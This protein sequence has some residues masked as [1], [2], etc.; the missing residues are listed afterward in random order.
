MRRL[1]ITALST[2]ILLCAP[3]SNP[4]GC[5]PHSIAWSSLMTN[6]L[7]VVAP[8]A[9][10]SAS[11]RGGAPSA[12]GSISLEPGKPVER[13]LSGGQSHSYKIALVSGQYLHIEV[14]QRGIDVAV[15]L[16]T[17]GDK[18]IGDVDVERGAAGTETI[19]AIAETAGAYRI[20]ARSPEKA[21]KTGRYEIRIK[22]LREATAEDKHRVA[23]DSVFR[24]TEKLKRRTAEEKRKSVERYYEELELYRR[25][26]DRSMEAVTLSSI[27]AGLSPSG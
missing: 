4:Q 8:P 24:E 13:E 10:A 5:G 14:E 3:I 7:W 19:L 6:L 25:A 2:L 26:G 12:Q 27:G 15:A 16:L 21:A 17:P 23:A 20:E 1:T 9:H 22:E 11:E 18:Q